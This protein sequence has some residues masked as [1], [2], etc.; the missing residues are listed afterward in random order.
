MYKCKY[1]YMLKELKIGIYN[2][3]QKNFWWLL[4]VVSPLTSELALKI[5]TAIFI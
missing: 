5:T 3:K 1:I 4:E 2:V